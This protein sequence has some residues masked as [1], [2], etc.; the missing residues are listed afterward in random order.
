MCWAE[1][2]IFFSWVGLVPYLELLW[3]N[4]SISLLG[5]TSS[6]LRTFRAGPVKITP[7]IL[8]TWFCPSCAFADDQGKWKREDWRI[9]DGPTVWQAN[10]EAML[11]QKQT[12]RSQ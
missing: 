7:Y 8:Q 12:K 1:R 4:Q 5:G 10:V 6:I 2:V 9:I 11:M 3:Q